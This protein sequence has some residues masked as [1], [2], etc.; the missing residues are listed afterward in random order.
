MAV[1]AKV[2]PEELEAEGLRPDAAAV[3]RRLLRDGNPPAEHPP[4]GDQEL[5]VHTSETGD[6]RVF[7][8]APKNLPPRELERVRK[9]AERLARDFAHDSLHEEG[10]TD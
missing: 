7:F 3:L 6:M 8:M 1:V 9:I 2:S 5:E 10:E 4:A